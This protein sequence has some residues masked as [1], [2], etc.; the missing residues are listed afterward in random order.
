MF[1]VR[2]IRHRSKL[3]IET[4]FLKIAEQKPKEGVPL[5]PYWSYDDILKNYGGGANAMNV[6]AHSAH[7]LV[8]QLLCK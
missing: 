3:I 4:I 2:L 8:L 7:F 1:F 6:Q 5:L